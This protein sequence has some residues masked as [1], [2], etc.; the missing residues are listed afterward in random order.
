[1]SVGIT[2]GRASTTAA[3]TTVR[4]PPVPYILDPMSPL[5]RRSE[6]SVAR[7]AAANQEVERLRARSVEDLAADVL[8]GLG[9]DGPTRGTSIRAQ[10]LAEYLLRDFPG[11]GQRPTLDLL[12][13]VRRAIDLLED[14]GLVSPISVQR[15]PVWRITPRGQRALADGRRAAAPAGALSELGDGRCGAELL[16]LLALVEAP[17]DVLFGILVAELFLAFAETALDVLLGV[18][19]R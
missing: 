6:E 11:A 19:P 15:E 9:P 17:L 3:G 5:F 16:L 2:G 14:A 10:Q 8:I 1:M 13:A 18:V 7:R 12:P 4:S